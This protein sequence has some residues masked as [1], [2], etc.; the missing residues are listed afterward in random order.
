MKRILPLCLAV[1]CT[2]VARPDEH[3]ELLSPSTVA[4]NVFSITNITTLAS[5]AGTFSHTNVIVRTQF[6]QTFDTRAFTNYPEANQ[7]LLLEYIGDGWY[8]VGRSASTNALSY[9]IANQGAAP[10]KYGILIYRRDPPAPVLKGVRM[11]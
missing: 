3:F 2:A 10:K 1:L 9:T 6:N 4:T 5:E 8:A 7:L 11:L